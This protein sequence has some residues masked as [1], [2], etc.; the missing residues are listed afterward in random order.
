MLFKV[1]D[2]SGSNFS[3][4][5]VQ[6]RGWRGVQNAKFAFFSS[7]LIENQKLYIVSK[8]QPAKSIRSGDMGISLLFDL[9]KKAVLCI[10][11]LQIV[12]ASWN[13]VCTCSRCSKCSRL[14]SEQLLPIWFFFLHISPVFYHYSFHFPIPLQLKNFWNAYIQPIC[15]VCGVELSKNSN[16]KRQLEKFH[17]ITKPLPQ[18]TS[19]CHK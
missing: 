2:F 6:G 16:V 19:G 4:T 17:C 10:P 1:L 13:L 12:P 18:N 3:Y 15:E 7:Q 11:P 9:L 5:T 8:N 14:E